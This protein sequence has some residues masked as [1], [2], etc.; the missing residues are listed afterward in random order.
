MKL[1]LEAKTASLLHKISDL[2]T[3]ENVEGYLVGGYVRDTL[4]DRPTRDID[5]ALPEALSIAPKLAEALG[6]KFFIMD[7]VNGIARVVLFDQTQGSQWH[8]DFSTLH[9]NIGL[10]LSLRDFT[11]NAMAINL[12]GLEGCHL[13]DP[14]RGKDDLERGTIRIVSKTVFQDDPLRLLRALRLSAEYNFT[15][16]EETEA[17]ME[18]QSQLICQVSGERVREELCRLLSTPRA[19]EFLYYMDQRGLLTAIIPELASTKGVDQPWVHF[20][21]VFQHSVE[22]VAAVELLLK[23][24]DFKDERDTIFTHY[25]SAY[26]PRFDKEPD[27]SVSRI[28]LLKLTALL[29]D[30]AK[31]QTRS[32]EPN[33]RAR[34]TGH[35]TEGSLIAG[36]I[37]QRLR[38]SNREIRAVQ[39]MIEAHLRLWQMGG[40]GKPTRRAIYRFFRDTGDTSNDI[41]LLSLADFLATQ[42]PKL[43]LVEWEKHC[44]M[45]EYILS[46]HEKEALKVTLGKLI[47]G[48]DLINI[49]DLKP[50]PMIGQILESLHEAQGI[51]EVVTREE[52]MAFARKQL[53]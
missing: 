46:E 30:I 53:A 2:I 34:F 51:G 1:S 11:I 3:R 35:T 41:I 42:G 27:S 13:I 37:L 32:L 29:H 47:D 8:L 38:F 25:L 45:M 12:R 52:A 26:I 36:D 21:D 16:S 48:H 49:L 14:F 31:P 23:S 40:D 5:I 22:T 7:K 28:A 9:E 24:A 33:G 43:D 4:L 44:I 10:D 18:A 15:I 6:G 20:W 50:G 19:A 17:L 39:T